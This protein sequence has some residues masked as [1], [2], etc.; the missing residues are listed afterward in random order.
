MGVD[1]LNKLVRV[2]IAATYTDAQ[3]QENNMAFLCT[4]PGG[5]DS[6]A[7]LGSAVQALY[8]THYV[9]KMAT[10]SQLYGY[11]V[12]T[13]MP[14]PIDTSVQAIALVPGTGSAIPMPTQVRP[15]LTWG[16]ALGG[17][18]GRGRL[19]LFTPDSSQQDPATL[20]PLAAFTTAISAL[21]TAIRAPITVGGSTWQLH[22]A[23]RIPGVPPAA[24]TYSSIAVTTGIGSQRFGTIRKSGNYG[25][26][27]LNP[28]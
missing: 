8:T 20:Y 28:W 5:G 3:V 18:G 14:R 25:K 1:A 26:T 2:T 12:Q 17:R 7:A 27:N 10:V 6:R 16:S 24:S 4:N 11:H 15:V 19:Y 22:I 21:A 13:L 23:H 9:P